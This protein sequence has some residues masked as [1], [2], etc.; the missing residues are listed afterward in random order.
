MKDLGYGDDYEYAHDYDDAIV[1]QRYLPDELGDVTYWKGVAR[2]A[3]KE[4]VERLERIKSGESQAA[5]RGGEEQGG[6]EK[7]RGGAEE[8]QGGAEKPRR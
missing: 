4:L 1:T 7:G 8:K 6:P 3:E 2:G 5:G